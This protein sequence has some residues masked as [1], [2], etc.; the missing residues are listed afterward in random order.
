MVVPLELNKK[1]VV[2]DDEPS[3]QEVVRGYLEKDG[4]L[5]YV[6]G[7]GQDGLALAER[8]KTYVLD[9][10]LAE[11]IVWRLDV[12]PALGQQP[13]NVTDIWHYGFTEMLN[14][15]I[16][17]SE[18]TD[19]TIA[20][21]ITAA[22]TELFITDNGVGIFKKIQTELRLLDERHSV[23]EL[24]KG[25]LTTDPKRHTGEGIFF[26]SRMFDDFA[27][28]SGNVYFSHQ[29]GDTDDWVLEHPS[30]KSGTTVWM[31][32]NNH[33]SRTTKKVFDQFTS[34][35]DFG[36]N[37]TVVPVRLAQY[38]DDKLI[39][40]S[41]A[42]RL[43]ARVDRFKTVMFDFSGVDSIGQ[44]FADEVFRVFPN[45]HPEVQIF[46]MKANSAVKRMIQRA[47]AAT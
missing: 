6:A 37:K 45:R 36:F 12:E 42:K 13:A 18:G 41:Q 47:R 25:K 30:P 11:D 9:E 28:M 27:I 26:S 10:S 15:A 29:F 43:L 22:T 33:T 14:N 31:K 32:L 24:A 8:A 38:G 5:V 21:K 3:V 35:D 34:G 44:A 4:Y 2:I 17:H 16:D 23:L 7:S 39:S 46:E 40:R 1:I 20:F 19:V